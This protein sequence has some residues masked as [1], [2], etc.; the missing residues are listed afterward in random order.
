MPLSPSLM[1]GRSYIA[2]GSH[3]GVDRLI[4]TAASAAQS[5]PD[6]ATEITLAATDEVLSRYGSQGN[7]GA[8]MKRMVERLCQAR[9]L[10]L[11]R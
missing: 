1:I 9:D 8:T 10:S 7:L 6:I 5:N 3:L 11:I 4:D 2:A